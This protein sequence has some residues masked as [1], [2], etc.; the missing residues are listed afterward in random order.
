MQGK[1]SKEFRIIKEFP[2]GSKVM[3]QNV[4]RRSKTDVRYEGPYTVHGTNKGNGQYVLTD[5]TG[6]LYS[7]DIPPHQIKLISQDTIASGDDFF[8]VQSII[9][10]E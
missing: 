9:D 10:H 7:W 5:A 1:F 6:A 3:I 2:V 4:N 8:E